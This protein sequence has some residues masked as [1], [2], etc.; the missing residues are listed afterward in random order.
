MA[1]FFI[2]ILV[3]FVY[4]MIV[5]SFLVQSPQK[6]VV[7]QVN[8]YAYEQALQMNLTDL[9]YTKYTSFSAA[10]LR[11]NIY[12]NYTIDYTTRETMNFATVFGILFSSI[13]GLL[14]GANMSGK[15][16]VTAKNLESD[17]RRSFIGPKRKCRIIHLISYVHMY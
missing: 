9:L 14:A 10:T 13:T 15:E 5:V 3:S 11:E 4:L 12:S 7:P 17:S 8:Q 1:T 6:I 16:R 2:F